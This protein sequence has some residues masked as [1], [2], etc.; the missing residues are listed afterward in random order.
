MSTTTAPPDAS[1]DLYTLDEI[2]ART[3]IEPAVLR[4]LTRQH[5]ARVP[6]AGDDP[7]RRYPPAAAD[8]LRRLARE[9]KEGD[10]AAHRRPLLSLAAQLRGPRRGPE[11]GREVPP[12]SQSAEVASVVASAEGGL[13]PP[14]LLP[15][16]VATAPAI[17]LTNAPTAT[18]VEERVS[19]ATAEA[20][21]PR[22][23]P[24]PAE[25]AVSELSGGPRRAAAG[26]RPRR[27]PA[28]LAAPAVPVASTPSP[29]QVP[30]AAAEVTAR[31]AAIEASQRRLE[32][33]I[34]AALAALREP[35]SG[36]VAEI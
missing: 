24:A 32:V 36:S 8:A 13:R 33:E 30:A 21:P 22:S 17:A 2:A 12:L 19:P 5:A 25:P 35:L 11:G 18:A 1:L 14:T 7:L 10:A 23:E 34:R 31:L 16:A 26:H 6:T 3:G 29:A 15:T 28:S 27:G 4:R 9:E 20:E